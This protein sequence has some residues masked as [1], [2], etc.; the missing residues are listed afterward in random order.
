MKKNLKI[1]VVFV[2]LMLLIG[3]SFFI[4]RSFGNK[5][6]SS[7]NTTNESVKIN[8]TSNTKSTTKSITETIEDSNDNSS[9]QST[10]GSSSKDNKT[11]T[12]SQSTSNSSEDNE[13][14]ESLNGVKEKFTVM[15]NDAFNSAKVMNDSP[16]G[17]D[18]HGYANTYNYGQTYELSN[19]ISSTSYNTT[20]NNE[21]I[22]IKKAKNEG[23]YLCSFD[24][25]GDNKVIFKIETYYIEPYNQMQLKSVT[26]TKDKNDFILS[27][28]GDS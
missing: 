5:S 4:F 10:S 27:H 26:P 9:N 23:N 18:L 25:M 19:W 2:V 6:N 7:N 1:I 14:D 20:I 15:I 16:N 21:S 28:M 24:I 17:Y 13:T 11:S 3:F 22:V 8:K 12:T